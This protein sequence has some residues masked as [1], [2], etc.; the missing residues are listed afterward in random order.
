M[1]KTKIKKKS[2]QQTKLLFNYYSFTKPHKTF[3]K[4]LLLY[5]NQAT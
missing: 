2:N 3:H 5:P 4:Y 1:N